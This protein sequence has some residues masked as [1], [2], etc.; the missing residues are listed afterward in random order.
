MYILTTLFFRVTDDGV[1]EE[2][3]TIFVTTFVNDMIS[4]C[5]GEGGIF[6]KHSSMEAEMK[7]RNF[8]GNSKSKLSRSSSRK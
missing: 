4:G 2:M 6:G 1:Y 8:S 3:S 5:P 7:N